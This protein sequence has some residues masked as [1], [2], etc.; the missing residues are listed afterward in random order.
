M[1]SAIFLFVAIL[2][3]NTCR[4]ILLKEK[5]FLNPRRRVNIVYKKDIFV[6]TV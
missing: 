6:Y 1:T 2:I 5:N 3:L 4:E